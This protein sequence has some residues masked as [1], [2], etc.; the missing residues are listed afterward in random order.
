MS[1]SGAWAARRFWNKVDVAATDGGYEV[2]LDEH[3]L[4][5]PGKRQL[6]LPTKALA[7][8]IAVEW[9]A[10]E[11][12]IAPDK[13]PLTRAA[14]SA[15]E[16]VSVQKPAVIA[17]L[18]EYGETDLLCYQ[19]DMP[20]ELAMDQRRL[21]DPLLAWAGQT[22]GLDL[23]VTTGI[24]P[25][26]QNPANKQAALSVLDGF[27]PFGL[28]ALHDLITLPGSL[29]LGLAVVAGKIDA[30]EAHNLSR[31]DEEHQARLWGRD[32]E[33]EEAAENKKQAILSAER[34]WQTLAEARSAGLAP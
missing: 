22:Y 14:N 10:Q 25:V 13:M 19:A 24:M 8:A 26:A 27:G 1:K 31:L 15:V 20:T 3:R 7:E 18:A 17:M 2:C 9:D 4:R 11:G 21:W 23:S 12:V 28:T 16:R 34:L 33:A 32:E 29:V 5:T 30:S 6:V